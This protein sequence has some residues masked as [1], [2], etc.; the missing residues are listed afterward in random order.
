M[1]IEDFIKEAHYKPN[2]YMAYHVG[3]ELAE[4]HPEKAVVQ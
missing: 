2:D 3:R 1:S 4:L